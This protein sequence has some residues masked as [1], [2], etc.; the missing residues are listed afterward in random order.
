MGQDLVAGRRRDGTE[1]PVEISLS[2]VETPEGTLAMAFVTDISERVEMQRATRQSE[3]LASLGTLAAG[4]AHEINNPLG[5]ISSRIEVVLLEAESEP[6]PP[7]PVDDLMTVHRHAARVARIAQR[8]LSSSRQSSTE[9]VPVDLSAVVE[10]TI[11]LARGQI[12]KSGVAIRATLAPALPPVRGNASALSQV[13]LNLLTSARDAS[14]EGGEIAVTTGLAPGDPP[15][16]E[17]VV[18]DRGRG[19]DA[20]TVA[21]IFDPFYTTTATGTALG[22]SI[23]YGIVRGHGGTITAAST[24]GEGTR[25]VVRLPLAAGEA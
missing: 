13:V 2:Y 4:I 6:L 20:D 21:R 23:T 25:F 8:M 1:F 12:E 22:L 3:R 11:L 10:D 5:M 9:R 16:I 17:I 24:P 7:G 19:M 14:P 18:A 15:S